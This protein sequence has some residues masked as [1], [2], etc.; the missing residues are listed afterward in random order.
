MDLKSKIRKRI[1]HRHI[2]GTHG[3]SWTSGSHRTNGATGSTGPTGADGVTGATGP[4]GTD[5]I[6]G[7]TGP[8]GT[9]GVTGATG[10]TGTDGITGTTGTDGRRRRHRTYWTFGCGRHYRGGITGPTGNTGPQGPRATTNQVY[11]SNSGSTSVSVIDK[12]TNQ[13]APSIPI[14]TNNQ[15]GLAINPLTN[16]VYVS[17]NTVPARVIVIDSRDNTVVTSITTGRNK[18]AVSVDTALNQIYAVNTSSAKVSVIDGNTNNIVA[19]V[20]TSSGDHQIAVNPAAGRYYV[21]N[22]NGNQVTVIDA[23]T[24]TVI[25]WES[26]NRSARRSDHKQH[27]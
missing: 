25:K 7:A 4:T 3:A 26:R 15:T 14:G 9:D 10:P 11:V 18:W 8:T 12:D 20:T 1:R 22:N 27:L 21:A 17:I 16:R 13:L 6:T 24:N 2:K 5:G 19:T 23:N